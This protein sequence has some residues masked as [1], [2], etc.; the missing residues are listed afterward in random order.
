MLFAKEIYQ[1]KIKNKGNGNRDE[2]RPVI[3][4]MVSSYQEL[5]NKIINNHNN[6]NGNDPFSFL[7]SDIGLSENN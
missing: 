2:D 6:N 7:H 1:G 4:T 3:Y 5:I